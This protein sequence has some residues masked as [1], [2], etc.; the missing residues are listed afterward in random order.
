[1]ERVKHITMCVVMS[2]SVCSAPRRCVATPKLCWQDVVIGYI[3]SLW[4]LRR[5]HLPSPISYL[6]SHI[7][8]LPSPISYLSSPISHPPF[9]IFTPAPHSN[10]YQLTSRAP[11]PDHPFHDPRP[12]IPYLW[13]IL[14]YFYLSFFLSYLQGFLN[15]LASVYH[16]TLLNSLLETIFFSFFSLA[17]CFIQ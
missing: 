8:Y 10:T 15:I 2:F 4:Y 13:P 11:L 3:S 17:F 16:Q 1:M 14:K 5:S 9:D 7:S 12:P 6:P